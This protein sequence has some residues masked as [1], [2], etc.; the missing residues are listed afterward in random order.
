M[1]GVCFVSP[2]A[3]AQKGTSMR[4]S[5][6]LPTLLASCL[7]LTAPAFADEPKIDPRVSTKPFEPREGAVDVLYGGLVTE[8]TKDS[9]TIQWTVNWVVSRDV[10]AKRFVVS[11]TL[12]AG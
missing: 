9:I 5:I 10:K 3:I 1:G 6:L 4:Y 12:A 7:H 8:V 2:V 11:E